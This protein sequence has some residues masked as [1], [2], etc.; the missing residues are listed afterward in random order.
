MAKVLGEAGR[1]LGQEAVNNQ[2]RIWTVVLLSTCLLSACGGF[3]ICLQF[4]G[5]RLSSWTTL[6]V[7][8][9]IG[10]LVLLISKCSGRRIADLERQ[11][12]NMR[13]GA[14]GEIA[15]AL[16]LEELPDSFRVINDITTPY[17]NLDHVV[18]GPTGVFVLETRD[19]RGLISPDRKGELLRN[20]EPTDGP[21]VCQFVKRIMAA[22]DGVK[23]LVPG[24][25]AYFKA[26]FVFTSAWVDAKWGETGNAD[27]VITE[28]LPDYIMMGK[29][30]TTLTDRKID[31]IARAFLAL[32]QMDKGFNGAPEANAHSRIQSKATA[33]DRLGKRHSIGDPVE[34]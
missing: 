32:A 11:R 22:R 8:L 6:A 19:W 20:G 1:Y 29:S 25:A 9:A 14:A 30:G 28:K 31:E 27:C 26:V 12:M 13:K 34:S 7:T 33:A 3:V 16:K 21:V 15:V 24:L 18:V 23:V 5:G 17:G 10:F 2:Y 4:R